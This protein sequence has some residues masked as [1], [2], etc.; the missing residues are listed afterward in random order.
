[1]G[2]TLEV[3]DGTNWV[4]KTLKMVRFTHGLTARELEKIDFTLVN[5]DV[6]VGQK[7]RAKRGA[8]IFFEGVVYERRKKH[9][10]RVEVE[11][12]AYSD[13]ILYDRYVVFRYYETGTTAG[14]IIRD[15]ADLEADVD[16]TNVDD[17]PSLLANWGV[18]NLPALQVMR[19]VARGTNYY[20]RMRPGK[21]LYF[22]PKTIGTPIYTITQDKI[23]EAEYSEDRCLRGLGRPARSRQRPVPHGQERGSEA[24]EHQAGPQQGIWPPAKDSHEPEHL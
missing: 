7:V 8:T 1:M 5:D 14:E 20:I 18:E 11:A 9:A 24:S 17:G 2:I 19:S 15:L 23:I 21:V 12:T 3:Y 16:T 10:G 6:A 22:K 13:L 4:G